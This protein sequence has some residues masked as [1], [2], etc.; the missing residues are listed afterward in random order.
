MSYSLHYSLAGYQPVYCQSD[1]II[2]FKGR[3]LYRANHELGDI[4]PICAL[5]LQTA[6]ARLPGRL[7]ARIFRVGIDAAAPI[8]DDWLLIAMRDTL[9]RV[10]LT[11]GEC[12]V[13]LH[14]EGGGRVLNLS[15]IV[16]PDSGGRTI[17]FG[18]YVTAFDGRPV[19]LWRRGTAE[20]AEWQVAATFPAGMVDHVHNIVQTPDGA[21]FVLTGDFGDA[22]GIWRSNPDLSLLEPIA[23]GNQGV[24]ACWL[25]Q[26]PNGEIVFAT[27]SQFEANHLRRLSG[28]TAQ[29]L[30]PILGSSI[31][32]YADASRVLFSTTVE[33]GELTGKRLR[34]IFERQPGPGIM[35]QDAAIYAYDGSDLALIH[36][37]RK[38]SWP[39]RLAQF[40]TFRFCNGSA[41]AD[42]FY[43][44]GVA[45]ERDD[46]HCLLFKCS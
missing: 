36:R 21:V 3:K 32:A 11:T 26:A 18:D 13:D 44:Y 37:A 5:P 10:S 40:G 4:R 14:I 43:A 46:G 41:P 8:Q 24:R 1:G 12:H 34:D 33:P 39:M 30:A 16:D 17:C 31:Y 28:G 9:Y 2:L 15:E 27:D 25:W 29:D 19:R 6:A 23:R 38:D 35:G 7:A 45:V 42:R 22:A 20:H